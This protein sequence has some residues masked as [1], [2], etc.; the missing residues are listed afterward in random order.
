MGHDKDRCFAPTLDRQEFDDELRR[1]HSVAVW[2]QV[3]PAYQTLVPITK[4]AA[5][6]MTARAL[7]IMPVWGRMSPEGCLELSLTSQWMD[8]IAEEKQRQEAL[9]ILDE[10]RHE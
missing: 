3:N 6:E 5:I 4:E 8:S 10:L 1:C 7:Q 9:S 2:V